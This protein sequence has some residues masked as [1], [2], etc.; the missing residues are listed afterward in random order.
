MDKDLVPVN[1]D[2]FLTSYPTSR[3]EIFGDDSPTW[4]RQEDVFKEDERNQSRR[5][6]KEL[7]KERW[8]TIY[9][10]PK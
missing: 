9:S 2:S 5:R 1:P 10:G 6:N 7:G 3:R 4:T 8:I